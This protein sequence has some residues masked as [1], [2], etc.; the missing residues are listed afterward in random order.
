MDKWV[1][2]YYKY[3]EDCEISIDRVE[4]FYSFEEAW[5]IETDYNGAECF[6]EISL[7]KER[8]VI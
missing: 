4:G 2:V 8:E 5:K 7:F 1:V 6:V 3:E